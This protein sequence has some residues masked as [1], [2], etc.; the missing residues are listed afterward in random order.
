MK[1]ITLLNEK[2]GVAKTT[3]SLH[4][5]AGLAI[6]GQRVMLIDADAQ[7]NATTGLGLPERGGMYELLY[8]EAE[9]ADVLVEP[10][11]DAYAGEHPVDG[12]L[13]VLPSD[14]QTRVIPLVID[15]VTAL[16]DRID[17]LSDLL[18]FVVIDTS[19]TPS[20]LHSMIYLASDYMVMP[21]QAEYGSLSGLAKS[22]GRVSKLQSL[23][24]AQV[25][26]A[27][28]LAGVVPT[29]YRGRTSAHQHGLEHL[30]ERF[31]N[32]VYKPVAERIAWA[33]AG[34][35]K[36]TLYAYAPDSPATLDAWAVTDRVA[37]S[38]GV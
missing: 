30:T 8:R 16:S 32:K 36:Q 26:P 6:R 31:G 1:V 19:P 3:L 18:D 7:A 24:K 17:E 2:G 34:Y 20:L 9:W 21:T 38:V 35:A 5:A 33:E 37:E 10:H 13:W 14:I 27:T 29:M 22:A 23:R 12:S 15:E 25:L 4:I 11:T 28:K